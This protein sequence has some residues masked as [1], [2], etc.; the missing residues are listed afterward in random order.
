MIALY[1]YPCYN[2]GRYKGTALYLLPLTFSKIRM[3]I[4]SGVSQLY[5]SNGLP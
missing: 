2:E 4:G 3:P 1:P 5:S